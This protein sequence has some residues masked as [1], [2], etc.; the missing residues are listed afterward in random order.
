MTAAEFALKRKV[1]TIVIIIVMFFLG[2]VSMLN[3]KQE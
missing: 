2:L 1:T 3:M